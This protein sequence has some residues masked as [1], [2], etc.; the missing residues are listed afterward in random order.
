MILYWSVG[1]LFIFMDVSNKPAFV[2][3]YKTQPEAHIPLDITKYAKS[4]MRCVFNQT[5]VGIPFT[6]FFYYVGK[7][8]G[9]HPL[10]TT[11]SFL[12]VMFDLL[13]MGILYEFGFFYSHRLM[14]HRLLYKYIH[15]I[16]HEWTA[17]V[18]TMAI[19]NIK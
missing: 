18:S 11:H 16:H 3:K 9:T 4:S 17:P 19:V 10:T 14:H 1:F 2:R 5:V 6:I 12:K 15:K 13:V 8:V 7:A